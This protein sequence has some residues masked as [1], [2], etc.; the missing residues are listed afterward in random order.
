VPRRLNELQLARLLA[1]FPGDGT[2]TIYQDIVRLPPA[3]LLV[4][5][6]GAVT[7]R[8]YWRMEDAPE[9]RLGSDAAYVEAFL[10][11][12]EAAVAA[13][14]RSTRPIGAT[15]S[16]GLDSGSVT[17]LAARQLRACGQGL[18]AFTAAPAFA[19]DRLFSPRILAD[20]WPAAQASAALAGVAEHI[21]VRAAGFS[22]SAA[23]AWSLGTFGEP[24]H[25]AANMHWLH[26]LHAAA[27]G[28][29]VGVLLTGQLGN[30]GVSWAGPAHLA[31]DLLRAGRAGAAL[32]ALRDY[33]AASGR[34]WPGAIRR[35]LLGP[36]RRSL[37]AAAWQ[38]RPSDAPWRGY[39]FLSRPFAR[40]I[41]LLERMRADG[42]DPT[43][44]Q[45]TSGAQRRID[46]LMPAKSPAG[47]FWHALGAAFGMEVRDPTADIRL[48]QFCLGLPD[49]QQ[50]RGDQGRLLIRRAMAGL[51][52]AEVL[53]AERFG[54]QAADLGQRMRADHEI[55]DQLLGRIERAPAA[56]EYLDLPAMRR[57]WAELRD[58]PTA[59]TNA[60]ALLR[61][62]DVGRLLL[63]L[64]AAGDTIG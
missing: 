54:L 18:A 24:Q 38:L 49:E 41:G 37:R 32:Q 48:I 55:L 45:P 47:A 16:A 35:Q 21:A 7:V 50:R 3:H 6:G 62:L 51:L 60:G 2:D 52:P 64:T 23:L 56:Q 42:H 26:D 27:Q 20:E 15:L 10:E 5:A 8:R 9:V 53:R 13:R 31:L 44:S 1:V 34:S 11:R 40:R 25:A 57:A 39:A 33:R 28:R 36:L 43:F 61:G 58:R 46:T 14:L 59:T 4:A 19:A 29:G 30:G 22:V 63:T 12:Y 17:A